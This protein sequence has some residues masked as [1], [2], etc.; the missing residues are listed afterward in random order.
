MLDTERILS[1]FSL[2]S[3]LEGK[4]LERCRPLC[5]LAGGRLERRLRPGA[6]NPDGV[7][8]ERLANA[9]AACAYA[10]Y[11]MMG[12]AAGS[13]D[14]IKVGDISVKSSAKGLDADA[15]DIR[16]YFLEQVTDLLLPEG[17]PPL[18]VIA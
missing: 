17:P 3:D 14:E 1:A 8:L 18:E 9:A 11:L 15:R 2:F 10:D 12:A 4:A 7:D 5:A 6:Q 13:A 16:D